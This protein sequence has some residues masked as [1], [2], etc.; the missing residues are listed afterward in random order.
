MANE[1]GHGVEI[2]VAVQKPVGHAPVISYKATG[3]LDTSENNG[4]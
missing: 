4:G 2:G 1:A 3:F